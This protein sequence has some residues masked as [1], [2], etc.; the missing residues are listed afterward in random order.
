MRQV[1]VRE[2]LFGLLVVFAMCTAASQEA[3][4]SRPSLKS[5]EIHRDGSVTFRLYAPE[6]NRVEVSGDFLMTGNPENQGAYV[7]EMTRNEDGVWEHTTPFALLSELYTYSFLVDGMR[8]NDP[9]NAFVCRDVATLSSYFI[10]Q[11]ETGDLYSVADVPHGNIEKVW[12]ASPSLN[13]VRRMSVYTPPGYRQG[14]DDYPVLYLLHGM[15][16][17]EEAW[18]TL[19]REAQ[20]LDN[21]IAAGKTR[22]MIVVMPNGNVSQQA[23]PG[24]SS[25]GLA[26]PE[27]MLPRTMNG[28]METS[29]M[30]IVTYV[31]SNYRTMQRK[32]GRAI[33]GLSMGG[34]HALHIS[35][36]YPELFDYV[37]LFSAAILPGGIGDDTLPII[38]TDFEKKLA[39]QFLNAPKLYWIGIGREDFLYEVNKEFRTTLDGMGVK[40][41]Y[42]ETEGGHTWR[43]WRIYLSAFVSSFFKELPGRD[44]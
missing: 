33:A 1:K 21:L 12:Y 27:F 2:I 30:D 35:K 14:K 9:S 6:A 38:Y 3:L 24:E 31:D 10:I 13:A 15:G 29:F 4:W 22:P 5:P 18:Q 39:V 28:E 11:G 8:I 34:F 37:G 7:G 32:E 20:I 19:G 25:G 16:G 23:A 40:Y 36:Y 42:R 41:V 44:R 43:N 17:D 26:Q